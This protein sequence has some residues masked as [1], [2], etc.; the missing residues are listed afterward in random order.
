MTGSLPS[1]CKKPPLISREEFDSLVN[2]VQSLTEDLELRGRALLT[3]LTNFNHDLASTVIATLPIAGATV[4]NEIGATVNNANSEITIG[5]G[6]RYD[7]WAN[8]SWFENPASN[9][10]RDNIRFWVEVNN[11][12]VGSH[13]QNNYLRDATGHNESSQTIDLRNLDLTA[14]DVVRIR[15]Q[16]VSGAGGVLRP[17]VGLEHDLIITRIK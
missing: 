1:P 6:G 4:L 5:E 11:A 9:T 3:R 15:R 8:V 12:K 10:Q 7:L 2:D 14:G 17:E 16:Q 13:Y